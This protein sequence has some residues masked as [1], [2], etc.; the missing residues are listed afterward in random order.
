MNLISPERIRDEFIATLSPRS[1]SQVLREMDSM[2][3]M[4]LLFPEI[5]PMKGCLQNE[6]HHLDVWGHTL[7][8]VQLL[9][10]VSGNPEDYFF[11]M[12]QAVAQY[13]AEEPVKGRQRS[14]LLKLAMIF[15]DSG[16]PHTRSVNSRG[17]IHFFGHEK[18][19]RELFE[20]AAVRLKLAGREI[21]VVG[22]LIAGHMRT[23]IF[24]REP[25]TNRA[26]YRLCRKFKK[27]VIGLFVLFL[28]DL[29]ASRGPARPDG[30]EIKTLDR[31]REALKKCLEAEK[32]L[33]KPL[34]NG[35]E[36][37]AYFGVDPGPYLGNI[38]KKLDELQGAGEITTRDEALSAVKALLSD[39]D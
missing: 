11:E 3:I 15:H 2:G 10:H 25:A 31:V 35:R 30:V 22:E 27:D 23:L 33:Q 9:E 34:L 17:R 16:K 38:L 18:V 21:K 14:A 28:A 24:T 12:G 4:D 13:C 7:E 1:A 37:M 32:E 29:G 5:G 6:Y 20:R 39:Q 36:V 8:A 26:V 19:S